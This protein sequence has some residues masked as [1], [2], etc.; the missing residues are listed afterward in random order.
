MLALCVVAMSIVFPV[1]S[2]AQSRALFSD[3]DASSGVGSRRLTADPMVIRSRQATVDLTLLAAAGSDSASG[4]GAERRAAR[5]VDLNLFTD[6][7]ITALLD[8]VEVVAPIGYAWVGQVAGTSGSEVVLA[9]ADG[10]LTGS[11][12]LPGRTFSVRKVEAAYVIAEVNTQTIPGD[13]VAIPQADSRAQGANGTM[14]VPLA[15]ASESGDVF[16][17]LLY[18]TT[19]VKN[20]A[21]GTGPLNSLIAGSIAQVNTAYAE[22]GIATRVRLVGALETSLVESGSTAIDLPALRANPEVRAARDQY[23]ADI[24]SLL[25]SGDPV[26]SGRS[27][28]TISQGQSWPDAAFGVL[29][30]YPQV[31]YIYSLAHELGHI[32]GCL[33]E[34][35]NNGGDDTRGAYPYSLGYTDMAHGFHD[36]MSYGVGCANCVGLN[37]FSNPISSYRGSPVGT[38]AQDSARTIN[39]TRAIVANYRAPAGAAG[40]PSRPTELMATAA[41]STVT[42]TWTAPSSGTPTAYIIEAGSSSGLVNL[43]NF[44]TNGTATSFLAGGVGSGTYY[45]RVRATNPAGT[46]GASNEVA[47]IVR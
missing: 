5:S 46:S 35:G 13:D 3:G 39:N 33:H 7:D 8:R 11:I 14:A 26:S 4:F 18:Y 6:V 23:G 19:A 9:V 43:A 16:D 24:V 36:L 44:S 28:V 47:L 20:A 31:G 32:Q 41:G 45:V 21:G 22:S 40:P 2:D 34:L 37:Q 38:G 10:V 1:R 27:Y 29:V 12:K 15:A 17:L 25:V 42:L 30:H